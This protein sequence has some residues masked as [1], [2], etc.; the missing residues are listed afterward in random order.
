VAREP[1][2]GDAFG[3]A[4]LDRQP[5][6]IERDDGLVDIDRSDYESP[7]DRW[8]PL[9]RWVL[10]QCRGRTLDVGAGAGRTTLVLQDREAGCVALD[11]SAGAIERCRRRG[12]RETFHGTI[13]D[14]A[15]TEH[16]G[17]DAV[18]LFGNNVGLLGG[19]DVAG[20]VLGVLGS[21][22]R[23]GGVVLGT[24]LDP[25]ATEDPVH[26]RYHDENRAGGRLGGEVTFR[27]RYRDLATEWI[28][29]WW[30]SPVELST[31]VEACGWRVDDVRPGAQYAVRLRPT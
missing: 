28:E 29:W 21:L 2:I 5:A 12:V 16:G 20:D 9:D 27:V 14:L 25:Y 26:L 11:V 8:G 1:R 19:P 4:L 31:V 10:S 23:P 7:P 6:I 22:L 17:F 18:A 24:M 15:A 30:A 3:A 13:A